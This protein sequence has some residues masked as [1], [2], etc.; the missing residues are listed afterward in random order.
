MDKDFCKRIEG[1]SLCSE[2][3]VFG[4]TNVIQYVR[5]CLTGEVNVSNGFNK[6]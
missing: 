2:F 4:I 3:D 6:T 5:D 1:N